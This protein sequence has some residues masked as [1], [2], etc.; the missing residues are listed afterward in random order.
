MDPLA[1]AVSFAACECASLSVQ[2]FSETDGVTY[3]AD[4]NPVTLEAMLGSSVTMRAT[5]TNTDPAGGTDPRATVLV[6]ADPRFFDVKQDNGSN[7]ADRQVLLPLSRTLAVFDSNPDG[8]LE[9]RDF[10]YINTEGVG[11]CQ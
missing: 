7:L 3:P 6:A 4:T 2:W 9:V 8:V 5:V 10:L 1:L 11:V